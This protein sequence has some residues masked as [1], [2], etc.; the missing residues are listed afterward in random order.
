MIN[1]I[2]FYKDLGTKSAEARN[3]HDEPRARFH[4]EHFRK[5]RGLENEDDRLLCS[6]VYDEAYRAA[7]HV[8][9]PEY[10]R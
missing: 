8:S 7:R 9:K 4:A 2:E 6:Q 10:F 3:Q 5:A 1:T